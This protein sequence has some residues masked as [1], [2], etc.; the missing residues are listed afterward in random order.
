MK[1]TESA[2]STALRLQMEAM[3]FEEIFE[4]YKN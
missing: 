4:E 1:L 2:Q 3:W